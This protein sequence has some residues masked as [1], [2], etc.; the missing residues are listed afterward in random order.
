MRQIRRVQKS[1][2]MSGLEDPRTCP[3]P[4]L[5]FAAGT[6]K[7]RE[8]EL[9]AGFTQPGAAQGPGVESDSGLTQ[10]FSALTLCSTGTPTP[11]SR[12]LGI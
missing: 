2:R 9:L 8:L 5:G 10:P 4:G 12:G 1:L 11:V 6:Q 7:A 3:S